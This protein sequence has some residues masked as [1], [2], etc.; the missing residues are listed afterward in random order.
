MKC[1]E[2]AVNSG[3]DLESRS[4]SGRGLGLHFIHADLK[5]AAL[6]AVFSKPR[7]RLTMFLPP[8]EGSMAS[9]RKRIQQLH[10][11][12][13]DG[14]GGGGGGGGSDGGGSDCI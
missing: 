9:L 11:C 13:G 6:A 8:D 3:T 14:G 5:Q 10:G 1:N 4:Q 2:F 12:C 7:R